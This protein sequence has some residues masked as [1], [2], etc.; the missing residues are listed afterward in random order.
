MGILHVGDPLSR[1]E[2]PVQKL[3]EEID[4]VRRGLDDMIVKLAA[5]AKLNDHH[6]NF[7][8]KDACDNAAL[9][10]QKAN[11]ELFYAQI[12]LGIHD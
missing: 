9:A 12:A 3:R 2:R 6:P 1:E 10:V 8:K 11:A 5:K 7:H 4:K